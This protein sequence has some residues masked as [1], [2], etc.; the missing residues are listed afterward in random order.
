MRIRYSK[1]D[2]RSAKAIG[3]SFGTGDDA[4]LRNNLPKKLMFFLLHNGAGREAFRANNYLTK[5]FRPS[6]LSS[7]IIQHF[8]S[9]SMSRA[10]PEAGPTHKFA[11]ALIIPLDV[12][13]ANCKQE[14]RIRY[15]ETPKEVA[16]SGLVHLNNAVRM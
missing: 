15:G 12:L 9:I 7:C 14:G 5:T 10:C 4:S 6:S 16:R 3:G 1:R 11:D 13:V 2:L 8:L